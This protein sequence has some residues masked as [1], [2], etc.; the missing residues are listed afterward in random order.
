MADQQSI[1]RRALLAT[2]GGAALATAVSP[3]HLPGETEPQ[4]DGAADNALE[5]VRQHGLGGYM[6][7]DHATSIV[8]ARQD[9]F[10]TS[11]RVPQGEAMPFRIRPATMEVFRADAT[12]DD[13]TR[14]GGWYWKCGDAEGKSRFRN[15]KT[16]LL[17]SHAGGGPL[18]M[19]VYQPDGVVHWYSLQMDLR[20]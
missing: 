3:D 9:L 2:L 13:F 15:G 16:P 10:V 17:T 12:V 8:D 4:G 18:V 5:D 14:E 6:F 11:A 1:N 19:A 7:L 20:C